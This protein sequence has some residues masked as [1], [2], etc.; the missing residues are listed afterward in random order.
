MH[1]LEC[2][3]IDECCGLNPPEM[4]WILVMEHPV[5]NNRVVYFGNKTTSNYQNTLLCIWNSKLLHLT[6]GKASFYNCVLVLI[7]TVIVLIFSLTRS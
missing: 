7:F 5:V 2:V 1:P 4:R 3:R 6:F